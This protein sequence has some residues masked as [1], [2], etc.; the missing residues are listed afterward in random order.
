MRV[1]GTARTPD[2]LLSCPVGIR[3]RK[4]ES[5]QRPHRN[6]DVLQDES[7]VNHQNILSLDDDDDDDYE[8]KIV[9]WIDSKVR[10]PL[11]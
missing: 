8:W 9:C 3:V 11:A 7:I 2:I 10:L 1:R 6:D 5:G 4:K